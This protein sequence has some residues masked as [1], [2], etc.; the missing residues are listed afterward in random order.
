MP[1]IAKCRSDR[2]HAAA[3]TGPCNSAKPRHRDRSG[4]HREMG[5]L[6]GAAVAFALLAAAAVAAAQAG[7]YKVRHLQLEEKLD[8]LFYAPDEPLGAPPPLVVLLPALGQPAG[9]AGLRRRAHVFASSGVAALVVSGPGA[10]PSHADA[11]SEVAD[12]AAAPC[13]P[14][15][16]AVDVSP[17]ARR[18]YWRAAAAA[19]RALGVARDADTSRVAYWGAEWGALPAAEA[20][21]AAPSGTVQTVL[22]EV[23]ANGGGGA[24]GG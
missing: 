14:P 9:A 20:A 21:L 6:P 10:P 5:R 24:G 15:P 7:P 1:P 3:Q 22:L 16:P 23:R 11:S 17:G 12:A 19:V 18:R 13:A 2:A 8:A 4:A